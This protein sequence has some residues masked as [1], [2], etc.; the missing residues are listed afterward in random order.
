LT[1][2]AALTNWAGDEVLPNSCRDVAH[3]CAVSAGR[4]HK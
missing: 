4:A 1:G 3:A 2:I